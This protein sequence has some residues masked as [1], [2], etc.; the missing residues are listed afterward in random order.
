MKDKV[1]SSFKTWSVLMAVFALGCITGVGI[2]GVYRAK[3]NAS[4]R[5]NRSRGDR[6]AMFEKMRSDLKLSDEQ[7]KEMHRVLDETANE[8][9]ALRGEL[10]P[11]YE[12]LRLKTRGRLRALL[13]AEQ[14]QKFDSLMTEIDA[15][16][17]KSESDGR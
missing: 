13:S 10:R 1:K 12:E 4:F 9:R 16:R 14:Q 8:F 2:D 15:R 7:S 17:Q 5:E 11:R 6:E 3:T